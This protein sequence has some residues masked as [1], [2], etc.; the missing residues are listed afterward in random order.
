MIMKSISTQSIQ[1]LKSVIVK[2]NCELS[3]TNVRP[4]EQCNLDSLVFVSSKAMLE[5]ALSNHARGFIVLEKIYPEIANLDLKN[6]FICT[7]SN[8]QWAM[9]EVLSLFD[10]NQSLNS[11]IH[12]SAVISPNATIGKNVTISAYAVIEDFAVIADHVQIGA[13]CWVGHHAQI[14]ENTILAPHVCI[15]SFCEIGQNCSL[16]SHTVIGSDGFGFFTDKNF[17]HH[18]IAQIGKVVIEDNV[19]L[20]AHCAIDRATMTETRIKSGSKF[21]NHCHIAHNCEIGE[22]SAIAAGFIVA[23]ST[24]IGKNFMSSG[25]VGVLG[26]LKIT[27]NVILTARTGVMES[28]HEPGVYGG[29]PAVPQTENLKVLASMPH[30]PKIKKQIAQ[31]MKHLGLEK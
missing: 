15:G 22:N 17:K 23:G 14:K 19:E 8:I 1:S 21:D 18:K 3:F 30:L 4:A 2:S 10:N 11:G 25:N 12:Q 29:Y 13:H 20:G 6:C 28:I 7:T 9:S 27:D 16:A 31:I 26:H 24:K 5:I